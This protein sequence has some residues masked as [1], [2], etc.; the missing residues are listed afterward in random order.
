M[1]KKGNRDLLDEVKDLP[2]LT[3]RREGPRSWH[4]KLGENNPEM[5]H[6]LERLVDAFLKKD[7]D[8]I[9]RLPTVSAMHEWCVKACESKGVRLPGRG[10]FADWVRQR[11]KRLEASDDEKENRSENTG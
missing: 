8:V 2:E 11:Q 1:A 5:L 6:Q 4:E 9:K 7:S 3:R 10:G